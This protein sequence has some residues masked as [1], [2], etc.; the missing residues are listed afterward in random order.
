MKL[1]LT[2]RVNKTK[3]EK[4][5]GIGFSLPGSCRCFDWVVF[6]SLVTS[7]FNPDSFHYNQWVHSKMINVIITETGLLRV[8]RS[9]W[10]W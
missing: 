5:T 6:L 2:E 1:T 3:S 4:E 9:D 7:V 8:I 10:R